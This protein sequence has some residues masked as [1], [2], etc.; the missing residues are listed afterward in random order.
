[1]DKDL[2]CEGVQGELFDILPGADVSRRPMWALVARNGIFV[3]GEAWRK[4]HCIFIS[5]IVPD[6]MNSYRKHWPC[7]ISEKDRIESFLEHVQVVLWRG[8]TASQATKPGT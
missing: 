5:W 8:R 7:L 1:M 3:L 6:N 2:A 4:K